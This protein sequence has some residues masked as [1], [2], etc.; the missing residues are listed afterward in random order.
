MSSRSLR[1]LVITALISAFALGA[2]PANAEPVVF[3]T[4]GAFDN[5]KFP[6][7]MRV[8]NLRQFPTKELLFG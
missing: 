8:A 6:G 4:V 3:G 2:A 1:A 5:Q 7:E